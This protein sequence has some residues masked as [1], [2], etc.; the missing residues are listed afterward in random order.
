[1]RAWQRDI[2]RHYLPHTLALAIPAGT[3][4]LPRPGE[5][6]GWAVNA[7]CSGALNPGA[8]RTRRTAVRADCAAGKNWMKR[9]GFAM[10]RRF[11]IRISK[12]NDEIVLVVCSAW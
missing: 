6:G 4:G 2:N 9:A 5:T 10:M 3:T 11:F 1:M 8:I 12:N 7:G